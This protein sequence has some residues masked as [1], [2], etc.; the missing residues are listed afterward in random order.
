MT[1]PGRIEK[2]TAEWRAQLTPEQ[3]AVTRRGATEPAFTGTHYRT[4]AAGEYRCVCCGALLFSSKD[5]YD[6]GS[7]WP[8]FTR[9]ADRE[10]AATSVDRSL[11]MVRTEASCARCDAH[12]GH[13]FPDGPPQETG[14]R[15]CINSAALDFRGSVRASEGGDDR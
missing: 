13:V 5:K 9:P 12:L 3:F 4:R 11:G 6:S 10:A 15:W 14:E 1:K 2:T 7:G 8:S